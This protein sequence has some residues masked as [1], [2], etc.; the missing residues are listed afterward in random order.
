M[1]ATASQASTTSAR[2]AGALGADDAACPCS[3]PAQRLA[4]ARRPA[5]PAAP[6]SCATL[7]DARDR[8]CEDRAHRRAHRLGAERVGGAGPERDRRGAEGQRAAQHRADVAGVARRPTARRRAARLTR[9]PAL[10]EDAEHAGARAEAPRR[11]RAARPRRRRRRAARRPPASRPAAAAA[12]RS[13]PSATKRRSRRRWSR[14]SSLSFSLWG[15]VITVGVGTKRAPIL[16][17]AA[18]GRLVRVGC[19]TR[20]PTPRGRRR[21]IGGRSRGRARRC[22]PAP[23]GRAR[24]RPASGR[25]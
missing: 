14:R 25:G 21:Q 23:C 4:R 13:S 16:R 6:G 7:A 3:G 10:L 15:L 20:R 1:W 24:S 12:S 17:G 8:H 22:R 2:Q 5:R 18:P 9:A 11:R 19:G